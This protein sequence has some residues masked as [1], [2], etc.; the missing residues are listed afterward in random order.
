MTVVQSGQSLRAELK[1]GRELMLH[2]LLLSQLLPWLI[3]KSLQHWDCGE[4]RL[5]GQEE[6]CG[7]VPNYGERLSEAGGH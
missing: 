2:S 3:H 6:G 7:I 5:E 1:F 4:Q